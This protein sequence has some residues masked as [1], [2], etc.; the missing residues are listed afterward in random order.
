MSD[1]NIDR[2]RKVTP[3]GSV[4]LFA[5]SGVAGYVN[6]IGASASF[7]GPR[8]LAIGASGT[9]F[10]ADCEGHRLRQVTSSGSVTLLAGSGMIGSADGTGAAASFNFPYGV[11]VGASGHVFVGDRSNQKIHACGQRGG[12][13]SQRRR[14]GRFL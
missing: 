4:S 11:A 6:G 2:I 12:G 14:R 8:G 7:N 3:V 9:V 13:V 5:G 10:V 1:F